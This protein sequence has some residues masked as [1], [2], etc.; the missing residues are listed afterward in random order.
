MSD[1]IYEGLSLIFISFCPILGF[2]RVSFK[3]LE[4]EHKN[5]K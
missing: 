5:Y 4:K 1:P 2:F 3:I